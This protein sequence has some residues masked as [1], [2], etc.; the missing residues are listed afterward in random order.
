[1]KLESKIGRLTS[2][3]KAGIALAFTALA[4]TSGLAATLQW[5]G[6]PG[7]SADTNWSDAANW[8]SPQQTY[9]NQVQFT[10]TGASLNSVFSV[11]NVIDNISGVAQM[12]IWELD[13]VPT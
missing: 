9:Y 3:T 7:T 8:T 1:M 10:G 12:P 4:T 5:I 11:N 2:R 6:V 13:F